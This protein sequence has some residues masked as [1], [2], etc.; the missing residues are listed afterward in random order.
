MWSYDP[1]PIPLGRLA[2]SVG[3]VR[4]N[5]AKAEGFFSTVPNVVC[6]AVQ[7]RNGPEP[8]SA[9]FRYQ[10]DPLALDARY[11]SRVDHALG[12]D[13]AGPGIVGQDERLCVLRYEDDGDYTIL[14]DGFAQVPQGDLSSTTEAVTFAGQG[15]AIREWD[16]P[17]PGA[18]FRD[19]R[20]VYIGDDV[21][22]DLPCRFNPDGVGNRTPIGGEK[23]ANN[24]QKIHSFI[25][26]TLIR[27]PPIAIKWSISEAVCYLLIQGNTNQTYTKYPGDFLAI[28]AMLRAKS[29][30]VGDSFDPTK[31]DETDSILIVSPDYDATGDPWPEAVGKLIRPHGFDF[32]FRLEKA[33]TGKP[34]TSLVFY[35]TDAANPIRPRD[36]YL[37]RVGEAIDPA[38][39]NVSVVSVVR[40]TSAVVNRFAVDTQPVRYQI[41]AVLAPMFVPAAADIVGDAI[42]A[43]Q[44]GNPGFVGLNAIKYR[45]YGLDEAGDG[46]WDFEAGATTTQTPNLDAV[47]GKPRPNPFEPGKTFPRYANR[48][49][50]PIGE[51]FSKAENKRLR[52]RLWFSRNY[53]G[54]RPGVWDRTGTWWEITAD[55]WALLP[56]R[57]GIRITTADLEVWHACKARAV[58]FAGTGEVPMG[59]KLG[60]VRSM[61]AAANAIGNP[62]ISF[63]LDAVIE[64]DRGLEVI[65]ESRPSSVARYVTEKRVNARDRF[66]RHVIHA[67]SAPDGKTIDDRNDEEDAT[68]FADAMRAAHEN[69]TFA[70]SVTI[71]RIT[72]AYE[73]GDLIQGVSGRTISFR[74]NGGDGRGEAAQYPAVVA[75]SW[76]FDGEQS[77]TLQLTDR[78]AE[79]PKERNT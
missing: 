21:Q 7:H 54:P 22:T 35:R 5:P 76:S 67:S 28:D 55:D 10:F 34:R 52:A 24:N 44:V 36:V 59:G 38:A 49:R 11:P 79:P 8:A 31:P 23:G 17:I 39:T 37:Q 74:T 66:V 1:P 18:V 9:R 30:K 20:Y 29:P 77:T 63:R 26:P 60:V 12:L 6:L 15:V 65:A 78:R 19:S 69:A 2:A 68:A 33:P 42:K 3:V 75:V 73:V 57:F 58:A 46:H 16:V 45:N 47:F 13:R 72:T 32:R 14:W 71:P 64:S 4:Y 70:G 53:A 51:L 48:P 27:L 50:K 43:F 61:N 41:S 25:D 62:R 56:D 40:D